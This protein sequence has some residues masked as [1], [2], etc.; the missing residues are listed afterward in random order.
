V[1]RSAVEL[2]LRRLVEPG[3]PAASVRLRPSLILRRSC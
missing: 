2:L 1:G 3:A